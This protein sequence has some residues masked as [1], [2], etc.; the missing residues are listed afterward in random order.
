LTC[1]SI[2]GHSV[3]QIRLILRIVP[4]D[5]ALSLPMLNQ[6]FGYVQRFDIVPVP[7]AESRLSP[8]P[9][10]TTRMYLL[11]RATRSDGTRTGDIIPI[12]QIRSFIHILPRFGRQ[13]D[14]RLTKEN[15]MEYCS[16][17]WLNKYIDK[18]TFYSFECQ[19]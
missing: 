9:D 11:K 16:E 2:L 15:C 6:F 7:S 19:E 5:V 4:K 17:F 13:A 8:V 12:T 10:S 18:E 1:R 14:V 3:A